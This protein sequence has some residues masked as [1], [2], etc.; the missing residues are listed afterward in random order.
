[1]AGSSDATRLLQWDGMAW[2]INSRGEGG[3]GLF[4][5]GTE[6]EFVRSSVLARLCL[7]VGIVSWNRTYSV[8]RMRGIGRS[9][10]FVWWNESSLHNKT[11]SRR[12]DSM[13]CFLKMGL[14]VVANPD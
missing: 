12:L 10:P 7:P 14:D 1:M 9:R 13:G 3:G 6:D 2:E 8:V 4:E 11:Q 5:V